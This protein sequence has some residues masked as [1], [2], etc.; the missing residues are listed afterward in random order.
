[1]GCL[2]ASPYPMEQSQVLAVPVRV[3]RS[4]NVRRMP[5]QGSLLAPW[6]GGGYGEIGFDYCCGDPIETIEAH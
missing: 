3:T 4:L 2:Y 5:A 1:L 6:V